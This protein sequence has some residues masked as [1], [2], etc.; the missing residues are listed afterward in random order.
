MK[1]LKTVA[2]TKA[3]EAMRAVVGTGVVAETGAVAVAVARVVVEI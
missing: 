3:T 2:A 1:T